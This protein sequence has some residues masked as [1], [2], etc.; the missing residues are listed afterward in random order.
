MVP[1]RFD[2]WPWISD[3]ESKNSKFRRIP[4]FCTYLCNL[5]F[6]GWEMREEFAK[7]RKNCENWPVYRPG[8][9]W[10]WGPTLRH[11]P[12]SYFFGGAYTDQVSR[13]SENGKGVKML[14]LTPWTDGRTGGM[15]DLYICG[16]ADKKYVFTEDIEYFVFFTR[17][18]VKRE[19]LIHP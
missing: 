4:S 11:M 8:W 19:R 5:N 1:E 10:P 7:M 18:L 13:K 2:L 16:A 15:V 17:R 12:G 14:W 6:I 9:P 3:L